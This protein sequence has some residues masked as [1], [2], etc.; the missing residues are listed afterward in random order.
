MNNTDNRSR[1]F[2]SET[3]VCG[4]ENLIIIK[5]PGPAKGQGLGG[6]IFVEEFDHTM[7]K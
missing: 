5:R 7:P 2:D 3:T 1:T 6:A 4:D